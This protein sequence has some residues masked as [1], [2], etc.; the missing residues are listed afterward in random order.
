LLDDTDLAV[1]DIAFASGFGSLRQFNRAMRDVFH[2]PPTTLR[3]RRRRADRLAADGGLA[4]RIPVLAGYSWP[5]VLGALADRAIPGVEAVDGTTYRRTITVAGTPGL[6]EVSATEPD[7][8]L[9]RLHLPYW[10]GL[11]HVV[12]N[13]ALLV[14]AETGYP[15]VAWS[16]FEASVADI[17]SRP[18]MGAL[19]DALGSPVPGLPA[20]LTHTFPVPAALTEPALGLLGLPADAVVALTALAATED[21]VPA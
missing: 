3:Q 10:E 7:S 6:V 12:S 17:V 21:L 4:L 19:V 9:L 13:I 8:V 15:A 1:A 14:G 18:G 5:V 2:D 11:I 16:P 20:G